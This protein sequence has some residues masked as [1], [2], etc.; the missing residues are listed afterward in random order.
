MTASWLVG[1]IALYAPAGLG[2][3]EVVF[4][5]SLSALPESMRIALPVLTRGCLLAT[6]GLAFIAALAWTA[7]AHRRSGVGG[8]SEAG[9]GR[10]QVGTGENSG[11]A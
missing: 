7:I 4:Y 6:E 8:E 9:A 1:A 10:T 2:V 11:D 5:V 3:R